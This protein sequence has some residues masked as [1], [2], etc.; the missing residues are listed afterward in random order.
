MGNRGKKVWRVK[1]RIGSSGGH[2]D[3][4]RKRSAK[5]YAGSLRKEA[6]GHKHRIRVVQKT[7]PKGVKF[8]ET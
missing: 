3:F 6:R 7:Y 8:I 2:K 1:A 4:L 5:A